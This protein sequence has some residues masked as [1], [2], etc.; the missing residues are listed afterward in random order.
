MAANTFLLLCKYGGYL[1]LEEGG[2]VGGSYE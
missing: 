1:L 2:R